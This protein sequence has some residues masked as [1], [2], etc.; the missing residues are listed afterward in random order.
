M[1]CAFK[2]QY[3]HAIASLADCDPMYAESTMSALCLWGL[4]PWCIQRWQLHSCQHVCI[5][6]SNTLHFCMS[7][8]WAVYQ[9]H[10][11]TS[12]THTCF[13]GQDHFTLC[14]IVA[15]SKLVP[16]YNPKCV[17]RIR[18]QLYNHSLLLCYN[19][20]PLH[21]RTVACGLFPR[22]K[23][24][25]QLHWE[26]GNNLACCSIP[27]QKHSASWYHIGVLNDWRVWNTWNYM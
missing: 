7:W 4:G 8:S 1:C 19:T 26:V 15:C 25:T 22:D 27:V 14:T 11:P 24:H 17:V 13:I 2:K 20:F 21:Q 23:I 12:S 3:F 9:L 10:T 16:C 6:F 18:L 5:V